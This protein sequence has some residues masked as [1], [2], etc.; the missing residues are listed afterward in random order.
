[1]QYC[2]HERLEAIMDVVRNKFISYLG[3]TAAKN[4]LEAKGSIACGPT[5]L[6]G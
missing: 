3:T 5:Q 1:M 6:C 4:I 2:L